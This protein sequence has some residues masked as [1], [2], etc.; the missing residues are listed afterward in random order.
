MSS[1]ACQWVFQVRAPIRPHQTT[2][3]QILG[4][5]S[6]PRG[7]LTVLWD[8]THHSS[9]MCTSIPR[10]AVPKNQFVDQ[11]TDHESPSKTM[12]RSSRPQSSPSPSHLH[13]PP[14]PPS[15]L[16]PSTSP[17]T[18]VPPPWQVQKF[19]NHEGEYGWFFSSSDH[20]LSA[21]ITNISEINLGDVYL[22]W[23]VTMNK[24]QTWAWSFDGESHRWSPTYEGQHVQ[25]AS[26]GIRIL[27]V[28]GGHCPSLVQQNTWDKVYK[29]RPAVTIRPPF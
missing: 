8:F 16:S 10:S 19:R 9:G 23:I 15:R 12:P 14:P 3:L 5:P 21:P 25:T 2:V 26:G 6:E 22:H 24:C 11:D 18:S 7:S 27:A 28:M 1:E 17:E 20:M 13:S 29:R 4:R